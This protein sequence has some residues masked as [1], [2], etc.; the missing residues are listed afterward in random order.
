SPQPHER[1]LVRGGCDDHGMLHGSGAQV[2][3]DELAD[4]PAPLTDEAQH[5][6]IRGGAAG[7][8]AEQGRLANARAP[9]DADPLTTGDRAERVDHPDSDGERLVDTAPLQR[10]WDRRLDPDR[11][12]GRRTAPVERGASPVEHTPE[13]LVRG[14]DGEALRPDPDPVAPADPGDVAEQEGTGSLRAE[15]HDLAEAVAGWA[16][17]ADDVTHAHRQ[18]PDLDLV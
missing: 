17:D 6:Q 10:R 14:V 2:V 5:G 16:G 3:L 11:R 13:Q 1:R 15:G 12:A 8:H 4:L 7:H 18:S 9:E